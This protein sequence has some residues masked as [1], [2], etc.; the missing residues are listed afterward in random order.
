MP[1]ADFN[2]DANN[3]YYH[4]GEISDWE[5]EYQLIHLE[6]MG[7]ATFNEKNI[8]YRN[9]IKSAIKSWLDAG[10]DASGWIRSSTCRFGSGRNLQLK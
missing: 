6:M 10:A 8:A 2:N 7:L 4:E 5:D 1:L 9:Y 3:F